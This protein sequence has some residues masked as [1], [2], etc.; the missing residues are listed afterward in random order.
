MFIAVILGV[1]FLYFNVFAYGPCYDYKALSLVVSE[2]TG[3]LLE[4]SGIIEGGSTEEGVYPEGGSWIVVYAV[5]DLQYSIDGGSW[6]SFGFGDWWLTQEGYN[7][8]EGSYQL[9]DYK[10]NKKIDI[11][12]LSDGTHTISVKVIG[13]GPCPNQ[14]IVKTETFLKYSPESPSIVPLS[15]MGYFN[16]LNPNPKFEGQVRD[17]NG[18]KVHAHFQVIGS[19]S[20]VGS[21]VNSGEISS[22]GPATFF[23]DGTYFWYSWAENSIG[24]IS[25]DSEIYTFTRDTV[26][27]NASISYPNGNFCNSSIPVLLIESDERTGISEGNVEVRSRLIGGTWGSW[28]TNGIPSS[29]KTTDDFFIL[30]ILV[31]NTNFAT[32]S[33]MAQEIFPNGFL[34]E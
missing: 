4:I 15:P 3:S 21:E 28:T 16:I 5:T 26:F 31:A 11:S 34:A 9:Y 18:L 12:G 23:E 13:G 22:F 2:P 19:G 20:F 30:Q 27:P 32:A 24:L 33:L 1:L 8:C 17:D 14:D 7:G 10:F 6:N 25:S 29:G